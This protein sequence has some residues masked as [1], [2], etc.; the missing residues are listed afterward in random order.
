MDGLPYPATTSF[1][2]LTARIWGMEMKFW[3]FC[4]P[5]SVSC[6]ISL[7]CPMTITSTRAAL[8][9]RD[10]KAGCFVEIVTQYSLPFPGDGIQAPAL[11]RRMGRALPRCQAGQHPCPFF[12]ELPIHGFQLPAADQ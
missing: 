11:L 1:K 2:I 3:L 8:H 9:F 5:I 12:I 4:F 7:L 6:L 10:R